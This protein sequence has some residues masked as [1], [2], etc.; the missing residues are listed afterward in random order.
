SCDERH[1]VPAFARTTILGRNQFLVC[2]LALL[3]AFA[4]SSIAGAAETFTA[5]GSVEIAFTP[6]DAIDTKIA[7]AIDRAE[8]EVLVLAY[9]FT[10]PR[11]ARALAGAHARDVSVMIV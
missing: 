6:G 11:I 5:R 2:F 3:V 8:K 10:N 9:S 7:A 1:W 4:S